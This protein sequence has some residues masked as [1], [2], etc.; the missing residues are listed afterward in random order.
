MAFDTTVQNS[1]S[2]HL[3]KKHKSFL[4]PH[5]HGF[6]LLVDDVHLPVDHL[7]GHEGAV[8]VVRRE[9][10][11]EHS[12]GHRGRLAKTGKRGGK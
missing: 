3:L 12:G 2:P 7:A 8:G 6:R 10:D 5:L 4:T 11:A 1:A 9:L